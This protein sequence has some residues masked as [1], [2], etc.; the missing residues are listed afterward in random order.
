MSLK[1][2]TLPLH[3]K[4]FTDLENPEESGAQNGQNRTQVCYTDLVIY[5][6]IIIIIIIKAFISED[7]HERS[8][9]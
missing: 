4:L 8:Y 3:T 7:V 6:G 2:K 1:S 5:F 9:R